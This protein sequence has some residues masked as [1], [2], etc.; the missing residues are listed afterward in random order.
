MFTLPEEIAAACAPLFEAVPLES[1]MGKLV[2][3]TLQKTDL[4]NQV[5]QSPALTNRPEL[6][7]GLWLYVGDLDRSHAISQ[8]LNDATG[9]YW[10]GIMHRRE[11][12]FSNSHYW[13]RQARS[14]PLRREHPEI[15]P[16]ALID[17]VAA[18]RGVDLPALVERQR[19][20]WKALFEWC[21]AQC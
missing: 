10:H 5:L 12:D 13:M 17:A 11:G 21:A 9:A 16:D 7:A 3:S 6:A 4:V 15:D 20:E 18:A 19:Q 2:G 1:A 8:S 14:H